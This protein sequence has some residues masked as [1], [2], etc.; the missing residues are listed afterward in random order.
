MDCKQKTLFFFKSFH[1]S[2]LDIS[3]WRREWDSNP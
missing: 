3:E 1:N 2:K